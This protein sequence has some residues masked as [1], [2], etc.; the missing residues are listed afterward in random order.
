[1]TW[2]P[3]W[4]PFLPGSGKTGRCLLS[5]SVLFSFTWGVHILLLG[6]VRV[7][8]LFGLNQG[9]KTQK[10]RAQS[11]LREY[12]LWTWPRKFTKSILKKNTGHFSK[13]FRVNNSR[14]SKLVQIF[15][16]PDAILR[17]FCLTL[18]HGLSFSFWIEERGNN[19]FFIVRRRK[20]KRQEG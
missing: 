9:H 15:S 14:W 18:Y 11:A 20:S 6:V 17:V 5:G 2:F 1:M 4:L 10:C 3:R 7:A 12:P 13:Y 19:F 8:A 16:I